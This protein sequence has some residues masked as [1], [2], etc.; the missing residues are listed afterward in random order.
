M[1]GESGQDA[2][3]LV[4]VFAAVLQAAAPFVR[5]RQNAVDV[6]ISGQ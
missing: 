4:V 2:V 3:Q 6:W 1:L 5:Q